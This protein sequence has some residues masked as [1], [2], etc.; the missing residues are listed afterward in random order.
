MDERNSPRV[1]VTVKHIIIEYMM[2]Q[3]PDIDIGC[4]ERDL[5]SQELIDDPWKWIPE[6]Q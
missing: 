6:L 2:S 4:R 3:S 5:W 1:N